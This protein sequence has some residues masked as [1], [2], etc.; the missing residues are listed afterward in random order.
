MKFALSLLIDHVR[1]GYWIFAILFNSMQ[2]LLII[3]GT[4]CGYF[5]ISIEFAIVSIDLATHR[6]IN[7]ENKWTISNNILPT[8]PYFYS[9]YLYRSMHYILPLCLFSEPSFT[10]CSR[11]SGMRK[12]LSTFWL[13]CL[14]WVSLYVEWCTLVWLQL[15]MWRITVIVWSGQ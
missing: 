1:D 10:L 8:H 11:G 13:S 12:G 6:S 5:C 3:M 14:V 15:C 7:F 9:R 2:V 4:I